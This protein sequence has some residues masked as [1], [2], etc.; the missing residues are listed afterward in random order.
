M[1]TRQRQFS[2][3]IAEPYGGLLK[4]R[5]ADDVVQ[6]HGLSRV[7]VAYLKSENDFWVG[8]LPCLRKCRILKTILLGCYQMKKAFG[9]RVR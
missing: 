6:A 3:T 1:V 9:M 5:S 7:S 4:M 8:R 2:L